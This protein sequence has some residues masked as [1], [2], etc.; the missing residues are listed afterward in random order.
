MAQFVQLLKHWLCDMRS[1]TVVKNWA[2]SADKCWLQVQFSAHL[3][4]LLSILLKYN[5]FARTEKAVVDQTS[6]RPPNSDHDY[7]LVQGGL[8]EMLWSFFSVQPLSWLLPVVI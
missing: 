4:N 3:I 6:S 2:H 1:G 8:W 5:G 7:F